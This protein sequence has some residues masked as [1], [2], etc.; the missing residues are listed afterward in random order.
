MSVFLRF[1]VVIFRGLQKSFNDFLIYFQIN[2]IFDCYKCFSLTYKAGLETVYNQNRYS[3]ELIKF[4][5][6]L[7]ITVTKSFYPQLTVTKTINL[8]PKTGY[9]R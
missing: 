5:G 2:P 8:A 6:T 3:R 1:Y 9:Y 4:L 7:T